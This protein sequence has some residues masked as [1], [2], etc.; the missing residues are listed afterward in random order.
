MESV[1]VL[2]ALAA[3]EGWRVHHM[4]V[5]SAFLNA[6]LK[7]EVYVCQP[8]SFAIVVQEEKVYHLRH[9]PCTRNVKLDTT[10]MEVGFQ[11]S[12]HEATVYQRGSGRTVLLVNVYIDN[13]IITSIEEMEV[14]AFKAQMKM[15]FN[16]TN[17]GVLSFY[18]GI[19]VRQDASNIILRK[20]HYAKRIL[21]LGELDGY[22]PAHSLMKKELKLSH[23]STA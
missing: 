11:Q 16:M 7:E 19:E 13:L 20:T 9:A 23:Q 22:N 8:P 18:L 1:W 2:L 12:T 17:F 15:A 21:E 5:K 3:Q 6:D 4:D 14:E 10:L